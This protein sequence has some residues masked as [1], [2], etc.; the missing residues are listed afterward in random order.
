MN[1]NSIL[2]GFLENCPG[3][4]TKKQIAYM[5]FDVLQSLDA[6]LKGVL[7]TALKLNTKDL[8]EAYDQYVKM[9]PREVSRSSYQ[10]GVTHSLE[11]VDTVMTRLQEGV[12]ACFTKEEIDEIQKSLVGDAPKIIVP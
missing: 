3:L 6:E 1:F 11:I 5:I 7:Q 4:G 2:D 10:T 12:G 9:S 8:N